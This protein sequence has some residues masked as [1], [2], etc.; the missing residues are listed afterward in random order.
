ML[1]VT[2]GRLALNFVHFYLVTSTFRWDDKQ[3][4]SSVFSFHNFLIFFK[5]QFR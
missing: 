5:P 1:V 4:N 3:L 2:A